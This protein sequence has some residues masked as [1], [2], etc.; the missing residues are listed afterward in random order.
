MQQSNLTKLL[1]CRAGL[2][3]AMTLLYDISTSDFEG[4]LAISLFNGS[5]KCLGWI[6]MTTEPAHVAQWYP[7]G[8]SIVMSSRYNFHIWKA[9][10]SSRLL[11]AIQYCNTVLTDRLF[12]LPEQHLSRINICRCFVF[13]LKKKI[14]ADWF[15]SI[16]LFS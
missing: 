6:S 7:A 12:P 3:T 11:H 9:F 13:C 10:Y 5:C 15:P 1:I 4:C 16:P 2:Y 14:T 8:P